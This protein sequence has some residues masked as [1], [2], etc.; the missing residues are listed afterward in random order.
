MQLKADNLVCSRGGR[1]VF[2]DLNF[3][4]SGG[5]ALVVTGRNGAGKSSLLRLMAGF[6]AP[7]SGTIMMVCCARGSL[8][9]AGQTLLGLRPDG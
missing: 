2:A 5:Q 3:S 4:L 7:A 1:E 8:V 9:R 6:L